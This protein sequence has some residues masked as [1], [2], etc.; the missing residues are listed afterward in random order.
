MFEKDRNIDRTMNK[1]NM[2]D[3]SQRFLIYTT[4]IV[5]FLFAA[6]QCIQS[7]IAYQTARSLEVVESRN[8]L[9]PEVTLC[10]DQTME[11]ETL[12]K[13]GYNS[14]TSYILGPWQGNSQSRIK[15]IW[16]ISDGILGPYGPNWFHECSTDNLILIPLPIQIP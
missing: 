5:S 3:S 4:G 14:R 13:Y 7:Y 11:T 6:R 15:L 16:L 8:F 12:R 9:L 10:L 2:F 1:L